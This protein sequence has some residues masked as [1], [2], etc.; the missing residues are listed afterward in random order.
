MSRRATMLSVAL[1]APVVL[2]VH[3]PAVAADPATSAPSVDRQ[4]W[5]QTMTLPILGPS[6]TSP[7]FQPGH[8]Y[9]GS[10]GGKES[11]RAFIHVETAG[12]EATSIAASRVLLTEVSSE[13][14]APVGGS[15]AACALAQPFAQQGQLQGHLP[16][17]D[18]RTRVD[19][20]RSADGRWTLELKV[21][22]QN[23]ATA[24]N[25]GLALL[26][27][28]GDPSVT[29]RVAFDAAK[30]TVDGGMPPAPSPPPVPDASPAS[31]PSSPPPVVSTAV[32]PSTF[33]VDT[34]SKT[35]TTPLPVLTR[36]AQVASVA[37]ARSAASPSAVPI[38]ALLALAALLATLARRRTLP[39]GVGRSRTKSSST[40]VL[41]WSAALAIALVPMLFGEATVYNAGLVLIFVIAALGLHLLVN[42]AG[43]LS[44]AHAGMVGLP[45]LVVIALSETHQISPLYLLPVG[46]AVGAA[47]G[48][49]VS[50]PALKAQGLQIALVTLTAGIAI[51]RFFL[52]QEWLV[53]VSG[54]RSAALP[55]LGPLTFRSS[56]DLY[57]LLVV[58]VAITLVVFW[59][60]MHSKLGRAWLWIAA[61]PPAASAFGVP[62]GTYKIA[63]YGAAGAFAGLGGGMLVAWVRQ[64]SP[65]AFPTTLSFTYLLAAV[66]AGP[67][68][69][70]GVVLA[71]LL[72]TGGPL[73]FSS[74]SSQVNR[75]ISYLGPVALLV[76]LTVYKA[77]LNGAGRNLMDRLSRSQHREA[78]NGQLLRVAGQRQDVDVG[79]AAEPDGDL[80]KSLRAPFFG[81]RSQPL[82]IASLVSAIAIAAGFLAIGLAWYHSGNTDQVWIQNQELISG[83]IGGLALVVLGVGVLVR[84]ELRH[85][86]AV[87][88][89]AI[90]HLARHESSTARPLV[91]AVAA[92]SP[93]EP[94][95]RARPLVGASRDLGPDR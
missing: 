47:T 34:S 59:S 91:D 77:G 45:A 94:S 71:G 92:D 54:S 28:V 55:R 20:T 19:L 66:L 1:L 85:R 22:A 16:A 44:L 86:D 38:F 13:T 72:I 23:W 30:T 64:L 14:V 75:V 24:Q 81:G 74:S 73:V 57:V 82:G 12:L 80:G 53:G 3:A 88:L 4:A 52:E 78:L 6:V 25:N 27:A 37:P 18:C 83:G 63:A 43:Q 11:A 61:D 48:I 5:A 50:L 69:A 26:P 9:V 95:R 51:N 10:T 79:H 29:F 62:V 70:G 46:V 39:G 58:V 56:K 87:L 67:G 68:F 76:N 21:F 41:G 31:I 33:H 84:N 49:L 2:L 17:V 32:T 42:W 8:L 7:A 15:V 36:P 40:A 93:K 89:N 90:D 65:Q 35:G 60:L